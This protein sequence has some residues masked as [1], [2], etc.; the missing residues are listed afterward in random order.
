M[1]ADKAGAS[2]RVNALPTRSG[3]ELGKGSAA[4]ADDGK[5]EKNIQ[6]GVDGPVRAAR[7]AGFWVY[8]GQ[9]Y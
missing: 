1:A 8:V 9:K 6:V 2:I 3:D 4:V 5:K 7:R